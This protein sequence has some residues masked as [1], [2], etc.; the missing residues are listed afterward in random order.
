MFHL[1]RW[2]LPARKLLRE[3]RNLGL[4]PLL[5]PALQVVRSRGGGGGSR[6]A[7]GIVSRRASSPPSGSRSSERGGSASG[8]SSVANECALASL[9]PSGA[10]EGGVARSQR[11]SLARYAPRLSLTIPCRTLYDVG[12]CGRL[13]RTAPACYPLVVPD[14]RIVEHGRIRELVHGQVV[15]VDR[16]RLS[17][18]RSSSRSRSEVESVEGGHRRGCSL[19]VCGRVAIGSG[20][21]TATALD[22]CA[23]FLG[24]TG[25]DTGLAVTG[26]GLLTATG[27]IVSVRVP[28]PAGEIGVTARGHTLSRVALVTARCHAGDN[29]PLLPA[30]GQARKDSGP[31]E[32]SRRV[33][34]QL[35]LSLLLFLKCLLQL[36]LLQEEL[37][38]RHF[39]LLCTILPGSFLACQ[40]P[41]PWER[42][43]VLRAWLH[44]LL[45]APSLEAP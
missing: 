22:V 9:A 18:S 13:R 2:L 40:D 21:L 17:R 41:L 35:S 44:R 32:I 14:L 27:H 31:D 43:A 45:V 7:P 42:L 39:R 37:L 30:R 23:L 16:G 5:F 11:S 34:R 10:G 25:L 4:L 36:L 6:D 19:A 15:F 33:L 24:E 1:R 28:L 26:R 29:L 8:L 3:F 38:Y 20:L 12:N